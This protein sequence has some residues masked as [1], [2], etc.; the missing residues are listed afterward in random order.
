MMS[1]QHKPLCHVCAVPLRPQAALALS[2]ER[3]WVCTGTPINNAVDDLYGQM[4]AIQLMPMSKKT[5]FDSAVKVSRRSCES[6]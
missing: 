5:W 4:A 3:R 1:A 6:S 2:T